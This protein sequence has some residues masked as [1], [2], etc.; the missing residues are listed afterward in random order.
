MGNSLS[1]RLRGIFQNKREE[2]WWERV[3]EN[4]RAFVALRGTGAFAHGGAGAF[5]LLEQGAAQGTRQRQAGSLA[6]HAVAIAV[7]LLLSGRWTKDVNHAGKIPSG[8]EPLLYSGTPP[9]IEDEGPGRGDG[10]GSHKGL[11]PPS[12]GDPA[13]HSPLVLLPPRLPDQQEHVL[14]IE[15]TVFGQEELRKVDALG[16]PWMKERNDSNGPRNHDGIGD[17][18]GQTMGTGRHD[19]V[20]ESDPDGPYARGAYPVACVYCPDP[21]YTDEA[22]H[23]KLQGSV[24]LRV[25]VTA[26]GRAGQVRMVKGLGFGLDDRAMEKVRIWRFEPARDASRKAIAQWVTVEATYRLF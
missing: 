12:A 6:L 20:G 4:A 25:F 14:P 23:A 8:S 17:T 24:T 19:G 5:D 13:R 2:S 21:E 18:P 1:V 11:L 7:L 3:A 9:R 26:D 10:S 16:L 15:P 22:R